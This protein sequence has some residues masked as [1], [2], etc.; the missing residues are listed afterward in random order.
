[1]AIFRFRFKIRLR[2][3]VAICIVGIAFSLYCL[4]KIFFMVR[5]FYKWNFVYC[6]VSFILYLH[7]FIS[8]FSWR[9]MMKKIFCTMFCK[10]TNFDFL[11]RTV[12]YIFK[13]NNSYCIIWK[14]KFSFS[15]RRTVDFNPVVRCYPWTSIMTRNEI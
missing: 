12:F 4:F 9:I 6:N 14:F 13:Q 15:E 2:S 1:M 7:C 3:Q 5:F 11:M 8:I 10:V